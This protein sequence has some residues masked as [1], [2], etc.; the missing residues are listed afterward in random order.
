MVDETLDFGWRWI[1]GG[2]L[3]IYSHLSLFHVCSLH[4]LMPLF[5]LYLYL[6]MKRCIV[7]DILYVIMI[8]VFWYQ[9]TA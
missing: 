2:I 8:V 5:F 3:S 4:T 1:L 9:L 6:V 7:D